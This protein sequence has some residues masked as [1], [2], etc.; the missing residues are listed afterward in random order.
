MK[1]SYGNLMA[2]ELEKIYRT[3]CADGM[4]THQPSIIDGFFS[5]SSSLKSALKNGIFKKIQ[6]NPAAFG[7]TDESYEADVLFTMPKENAKATFQ[8]LVNGK[9][10]N[11]ITTAAKA[12]IDAWNAEQK[13]QQNEYFDYNTP[14]YFAFSTESPDKNKQNVNIV[15]AQ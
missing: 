11:A 14:G 15:S 10:N 2:K 3:K 8:G 7:Y 6:A 5:A 4:G 9:P 12:I 13:A 1:I